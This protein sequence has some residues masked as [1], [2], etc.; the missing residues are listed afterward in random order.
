MGDACIDLRVDE[1]PGVV[2][3]ILK[4]RGRTLGRVPILFVFWL[5]LLLFPVPALLSRTDEWPG[6]PDEIGRTTKGSD[7]TIT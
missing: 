6:R 2:E 5:C 1:C 4:T 7:Y 3:R